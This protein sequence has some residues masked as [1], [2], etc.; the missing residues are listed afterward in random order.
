MKTTVIEESGANHISGAC[1]KL[2]DFY[3]GSSSMQE[4]RTRELLDS[5][6]YAKR[7]QEAMMPS[8]FE[9]SNLIGNHFIINKPKDIVGGDFYFV[10]RISSPNDMKRVA[11]AVAD[12]TGHGVPGAFMSMSSYGIL[13]NSL[14]EKKVNSPSEALD[15]LNFGIS[16]VFR[17]DSKM[18]KIRDGMDISFCVLDTELRTLEFAGANNKGLIIKS[19]KAVIELKPERQPIG[20]DEANKPFTN[21][22]VQLEKGDTLYLFSDGFKDQFGGPNGKK[23]GYKN[24]LKKLTEIC[25]EECG[26]QKESLESFFNEWRGDLEQVDDVLLLGVKI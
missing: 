17:T 5:I 8:K 12:C 23:L 20:Y 21:Q 9:I 11:I 24:L 13:K 14:T 1:Q 2:N 7:L 26:K 10:E 25:N 18:E 22:S 15:Y 19:N 4:E 16:K 3:S 6:T